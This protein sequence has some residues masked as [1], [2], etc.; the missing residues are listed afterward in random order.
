MNIKGTSV[1]NT[2]DFVK[3]KFPGRFDEWINILPP[4]IAKVMKNPIYATNWYP[5]HESV[6]KP[7]EGMAKVFYNGDRNKTAR[8]VGVYSAEI[9]LNGI[10][11]VFVKIASPQFVLG[12]ASQIA[13]TYYDPSDFKLIENTS[14]KA[15]MQFSRFEKKDELIMHRI[16]GWMEKT[17]EITLKNP[18]KVDIKQYPDMNMLKFAITAEWQ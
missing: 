1:K 14:N 4:E 12:R 18:I 11:K 5:L 8:E 13:A 9:A 3:L 2:V 16:A 6:I 17:L 15:V 7:M 10:Y